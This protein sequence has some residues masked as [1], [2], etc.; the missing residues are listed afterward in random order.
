MIKKRSS[1]ILAHITSLPSP[2][3]IGDIGPSSY[4]FIDF[5]VDCGQ[6]YWQFLPTGPTNGLFDNSPY[7]STS[8]FAGSP[9]LI[10]PELLFQAGLISRSDLDGIPAFSPYSAEFVEVRRY[11]DKLLHQAYLR[12]QPD[13]CPEYATFIATTAWLDEYAIF[14]TLKDLY[15]NSGWFA[16][17]HEFATHRQRSLQTLI[18]TQLEKINYF[19]F[20]QFEF[21]RQWRL[22]RQYATQQGIA[23]IGDLPIYVSYDSVDV[24]AHQ[25]IF[26]LD[27]ATL[28]PTKVS[29]VPPDYFS[30]TGQRWGNPLYEWHNRDENVQNLLLNWWSARFS[31]LFHLVD[32][33][34]IDH[35]R[36][37][38]SFWA[39]PED[40]ETAIEGEWLKGPGAVFFKKVAEKLGE[41]PIVAEDLG[42]ITPEVEALRD[43]LGFPGMKV[44]QFAFDGNKDN[45]FLP[46]NFQSPHCIVYTG[47]HDNDTT[48]G[49]YL[50]D[51][52]DDNLRATIKKMANRSLHDANAIHNDLMYLA[53]SSIAMLCIFPLQDILGFGNDCKMNHPGVAEGNWRWRC[54]QEFLT[55]EIAEKMKAN[56]N[57]FGRGRN[58]KAPGTRN[59]D[60]FCHKY[61]NGKNK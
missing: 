3:G 5:L 28:R 29:G 42:I 33:T 56:T 20:E 40:N 8:A 37:F 55:P 36:G 12:F 15:H 22:L 21:F 27:R 13:I 60:L 46:C 35:F 1:G 31:N 14:M 18:T 49:W 11:K 19:R 7:M 10:S 51:R 2:F 23:L 24:W 41:L 53:Q 17:P 30:K 25:A 52:L 47:T 59:E 50:S 6:S 58:C 45:S 38:E 16:W 32:M 54:A 4:A 34:R 48:V 39:I 43:E 61:Q 44:L 9:L 57:L 26:S